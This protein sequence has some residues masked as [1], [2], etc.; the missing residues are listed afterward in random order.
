VQAVVDPAQPRFK[1]KKPFVERIYPAV[2][3]IETVSY[4][5]GKRYKAGL[6]RILFGHERILFGRERILFGRELIKPLGYRGNCG[7]QL[8]H[9]LGKVSLSFQQ[10]FE[11]R[12]C[13]IIISHRAI[14]FST[15]RQEMQLRNR[16]LG[17]DSMSD[18]HCSRN[19]T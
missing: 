18:M 8:G 19:T 2:V 16:Y 9:L 14:I 13:C 5:T 4:F 15:G 11:H 7:A 10:S 17:P 6:Q 3:L 1:T 12:L